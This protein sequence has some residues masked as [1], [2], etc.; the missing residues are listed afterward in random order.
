MTD[1]KTESNVVLD[2]TVLVKGIVPPRRRKQ[3]SVYKERMR[4]NT[5]RNEDIAAQLLADMTI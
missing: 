2:T 1:D 4:F 5:A 3:D